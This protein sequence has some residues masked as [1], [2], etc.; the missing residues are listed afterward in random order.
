MGI[1][2]TK[3][4]RR[5]TADPQ[6][7]ALV[8]DHQR[9]GT[10]KIRLAVG[11]RGVRLRADDAHAP[12]VE[13]RERAGQIVDGHEQEVL[14]RA[15]GRLH[16]RRGERC[17]APSREEDSVDAGGLGAAQQAAEVLRILERVEHEDERGLT[18]LDGAGK[19]FVE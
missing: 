19:D 10:A 3:S 11:E 2:T 1:L 6:P 13:V 12:H 5:R 7:L 16:R 15:R 18:P 17:L 14:D 8:T 9:D 4:H